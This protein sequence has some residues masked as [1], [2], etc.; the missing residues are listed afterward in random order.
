MT[1]LR[2]IFEERTRIKCD[3][4]PERQ[5]ALDRTCDY[6]G[7]QRWRPNPETPESYLHTLLMTTFRPHLER[8][9][10]EPTK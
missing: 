8:I 5:A 3:G 7:G 4:D 10:P 1:D 6:L 2:C 9:E